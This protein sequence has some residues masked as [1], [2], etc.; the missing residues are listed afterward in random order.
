LKNAITSDKTWVY[1]YDVETKQ[2]TSHWKSPISPR[3]ENARRVLNSESN[4][5][6]FFDQ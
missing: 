4:A 5:A 3:P 1:G 6:C 2:Q